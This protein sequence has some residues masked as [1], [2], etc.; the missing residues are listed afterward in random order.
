MVE[1]KFDGKRIEDF[2]KK[3]LVKMLK[4]MFIYSRQLEAE[5]K[6]LNGAPDKDNI[7]KV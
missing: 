5:I 1:L 3:T 6:K 2:S 7:Q 4:E